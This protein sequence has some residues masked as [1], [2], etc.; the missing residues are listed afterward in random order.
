MADDGRA[1][2]VI[3]L[4]QRLNTAVQGRSPRSV[5]DP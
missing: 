1:A 4:V 5:G 2:R 3:E